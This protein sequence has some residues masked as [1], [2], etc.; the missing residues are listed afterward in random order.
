MYF[1]AWMDY[2]RTYIWLFKCLKC[3]ES[4]TDLPR[5]LLTSQIFGRLIDKS[6]QVYSKLNMFN[7]P[8]LAPTFP[9]WSMPKPCSVPCQRSRTVALSLTNLEANK[10][11][12][13][14]KWPN[15]LPLWNFVKIPVG[16]PGHSWGFCAMITAGDLPGLLTGHPK[17]VDRLELLQQL[18]LGFRS[19]LSTLR[20][21]ME[22]NGEPIGSNRREIASIRDVSPC[23]TWIW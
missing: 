7:Y 6:A 9:S 14:T 12:Y 15:D 1:Y 13:A 2:S 17:K 19:E 18:V 22:I 8:S 11:G 20:I 4:V 10:H 5:N 16:F 23:I 3:F 21:P